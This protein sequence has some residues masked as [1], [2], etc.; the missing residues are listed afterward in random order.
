[1]IGQDSASKPLSSSSD[2]PTSFLSADFFADS[3]SEAYT[4]EEDPMGEQR[5]LQVRNSTL[6]PSVFGSTTFS[7]TNN[8]LS[9]PKSSKQFNSGTSLDLSLGLSL[10]LGEYGLGDEVIAQ[11]VFTFTRSRSFFDPIDKPLILDGKKLSEDEN[12]NLDSLIASLA[13]PFQ[14]P[15]DFILTLSHTYISPTT[16]IGPKTVVMY[17]NIPK[18]SFSKDFLFS[19][20]NSLKFETSLLYSLNKSPSAE[21][22]MDSALFNLLESLANQS[23]N[24][25]IADYPSNAGDHLGHSISLS[26]S[27]LFGD[28]LM[29]TPLLSFSSLNFKEGVYKSRTDKL[30]NAGFSI[31]YPLFEWLSLTGNTNYIRKRTKGT[32]GEDEVL[33]FDTLATS[34]TLSVEHKF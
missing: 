18:V 4:L 2:E 19:S 33:S 28:K 12:F 17:Q 24:S 3:L 22:Q 20:G 14:I 8:P 9:Q 31:S 30:Y 16:Y 34:M 27:Q 29:I 23:G 7:H 6:S 26:Y 11:P 15:N 21:Q 5:L 1:M 25:L 13:I 32:E 10:G